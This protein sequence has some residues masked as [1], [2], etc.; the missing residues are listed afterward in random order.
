VTHDEQ[1]ADAIA[2]RFRAA[3]PPVLGR[4]HDGRFLLDLRGIESPDE[5][6]PVFPTWR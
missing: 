2:A 5:L 1:G 3:T 4:I 6:L